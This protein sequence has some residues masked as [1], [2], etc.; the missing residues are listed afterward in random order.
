MQEKPK[1][2]EA[3]IHDVRLRVA[4]SPQIIIG[5]A[6]SYK[7]GRPSNKGILNSCNVFSQYSCRAASSGNIVFK[8]PS[9]RRH[10]ALD[11]VLGL[12]AFNVASALDYQHNQSQK[13]CQCTP[14]RETRLEGRIIGN[15]SMVSSSS[16]FIAGALIHVS[17]QSKASPVPDNRAWNSASRRGLLLY[18]SNS[19]DP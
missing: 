11:Q 16:F 18:P 9:C 17:S 14:F 10:L 2:H 6:R 3:S 1:F 15:A 12:L 7:S 8:K 5:M 4:S 13:N 19:R